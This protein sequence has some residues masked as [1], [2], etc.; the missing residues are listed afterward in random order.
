VLLVIVLFNVAV[1]CEVILSPLVL[2]LSVA[3]QVKVLP[4]ILAVSGMF[5][6]AALQIV[7]VDALVIV[8][9]GF[10]VTVTV[11]GVP[12]QV[13]VVDVGVTV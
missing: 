6:V 3:I 4:P 2:G 12:V 8:G 9:A 7:A 5:T 13:P 1:L 10:T 11:C